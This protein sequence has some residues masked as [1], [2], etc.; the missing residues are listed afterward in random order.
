MAA[1]LETI[2]QES[3]AANDEAELGQQEDPFDG[4]LLQKVREG[5]LKEIVDAFEN[6]D[7]PMNGEVQSELRSCDLEGKSPLDLAACLGRFDILKELHQ[8]GAPIN[9]SSQSG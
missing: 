1:V 6:N 9:E 2:H 8:R 7:H 5:N 4:F 3:L